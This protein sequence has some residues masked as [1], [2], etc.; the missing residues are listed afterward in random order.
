MTFSF[1]TISFTLNSGTPILIPSALASFDLEMMQPSLFD[2]A[3]TGLL[4]SFG[5][6]TL[7]QET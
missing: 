3:T 7:S 4:F 5:L 1:L 6:K 2:N